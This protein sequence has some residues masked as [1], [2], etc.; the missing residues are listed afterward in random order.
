MGGAV[1]E[2]VA[3]GSQDI[4]L[5]GNPS[6]SYFRNV[7]KRHTNF[8]CESILQTIHGE[9]KFGNKIECVISRTGDLLTG[10]V[11]EIDLPKIE[12]K[13][14]KL[15]SWI[16][17]IGHYILQRMELQI[18][19]NAIDVQYGEWLEIWNE[20]TLSESYRTGY[21]NMVGKNITITDEKTLLIPLQFWFCKNYGLALPLVALQYH[22]VK[23]IITLAD[24][25]KCWKKD[26]E[27]Y[28]VNRVNQLVTIN[29]TITE[30]VST[31]FLESTNE[32]SDGE[33]DYFGMKLLWEDDLE[34]NV[35]NNRNFFNEKSLVL[36]NTQT[37]PNKTGY[38]YLL[39]NEPLKKYEIKDLRIYCDYIFLDTG[40]RKHFAQNKH[41]Y[42]IEQIQFNGIN[43]YS[44]GQESIKIPL[45]FNHPCKEIMW[46]NNLTFNQNLNQPFNFSD[47]IRE[48]GSN[49]IVDLILY[50]NGEERFTERKGDYFRL[51]VPFQKHSRIPSNFIY[52][53]SFAIKPEENQPSGSCNF[54][55]LNTA[56]LVINFKKNIDSLFTKIYSVN[57]NILNIINGMG[58]LAYSN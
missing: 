39:K 55:R 2:L 35:I 15:V 4:F 43:E 48:G 40:E 20:L 46:I 19:G 54:S 31:T 9:A 47:K 41:I 24:F 5:T 10:I 44:K 49:P 6:V 57:Y 22:E 34:V 53:Y 36:Q 3:K 18:G 14:N 45:E 50:I 42:L 51:M 30:D 8:S 16:N 23:L 37:F 28:Y 29:D 7:Y 32:H 17:S 58:G 56:E 52:N 1:M 12:G 13:R 27:Y 33:D 25:D 26:Y 11:V 21:E 38:V